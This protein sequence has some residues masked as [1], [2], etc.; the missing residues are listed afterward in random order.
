M[1]WHQFSLVRVLARD[2]AT[3]MTVQIVL[4]LSTYGLAAL[5]MSRYAHLNIRFLG[6]DLKTCFETTT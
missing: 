2:K 1:G 6:T 3:A 5:E 4:V